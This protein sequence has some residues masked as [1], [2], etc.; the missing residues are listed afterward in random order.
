MSHSH[1]GLCGADFGGGIFNPH[2]IMRIVYK[3][4]SLVIFTLHS[5]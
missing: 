5:T 3:I 1:V 4:F 2:F